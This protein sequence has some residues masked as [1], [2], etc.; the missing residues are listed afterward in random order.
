[1]TL[2]QEQ[3]TALRDAL[4]QTNVWRN[5]ELSQLLGVTGA[6]S[7]ALMAVRACVR[8][9]IKSQQLMWYGFWLIGAGM[10][11]LLGKR[12]EPMPA[13]A[14]ILGAGL[15]LVSLLML[16][17][18]AGIGVLMM[19]PCALLLG[20]GTA[21]TVLAMKGMTVSMRPI[22]RFLMPD[23]EPFAVDSTLQSTQRSTLCCGTVLSALLGVTLWLTPAPA[24]GMLAVAL[25]ELCVALNDPVDRRILGMV[26]RALTMEEEPGELRKYLN[27][28]LVEKHRQP[29]LVR[30]LIAVLRVTYRYRLK[31][32]ESIREDAKNPI[33]Y[34]CNH[35]NLYGPLACILH[36]PTHVRP[37]VISNIMV[38]EQE[39]AEYVYRYNFEPAA[40]LPGPLKWPVS[41]LVAHLSNWCMS[42]CIEGVPVY[43]DHPRQLMNTFRY[44]V[45]VLQCGDDMLIFP[46]NPNAISQDHGY[47]GSGVGPLFSG[48]A[49]LG[50]I[51]YNRT[52]KRCRF[53]PMYAHKKA[54]TLSFGEEILFDPDNAPIDERNRLV[55]EIDRQM[56]AMYEREEVLY[57]AKRKR[58]HRA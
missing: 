8:L 37:W 2:T 53:M 15:E 21:L 11:W 19:L 6:L 48:F 55:A 4:R 28:M 50:P 45:D 18:S 22:V 44:A 52:G 40:W 35:G 47:E 16:L 3:H 41:H 49:M 46:E 23:A 13:Y 17:C 42:K 5:Y 20:A 24:F 31:G 1:M 56:R 58:R 51:Y 43:R 38:N 9:T 27:A 33:V 26:Q 7:M 29:W 54:R 32:E 30:M 12:R 10:G 39:T 14:S 57:Q 25:A 36:I 34:L